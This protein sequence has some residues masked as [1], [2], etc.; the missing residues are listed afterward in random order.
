MVGEHGGKNGDNGTNVGMELR[1]LSFVHKMASL[2]R[3]GILYT[4]KSSGFFFCFFFNDDRM[5]I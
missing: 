2:K 3:D 4:R 5:I 1:S